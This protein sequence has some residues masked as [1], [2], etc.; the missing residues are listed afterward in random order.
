MEELDVQMELCAAAIEDLRTRLD[1]PGASSNKA[2]LGESSAARQSATE[3]QSHSS[4]VNRSVLSSL[5][6]YVWLQTRA[7]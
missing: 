2:A 1:E 6:M 4:P 3:L 7:S 5:F